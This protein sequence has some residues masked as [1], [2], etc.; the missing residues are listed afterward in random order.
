MTAGQRYEF[1][2]KGWLHL[3]GA[4]T[5]AEL[6]D[7]RAA[8]YAA[9]SGEPRPRAGPGSEGPRFDPRL[10]QLAFNQVAWPV[11]M[12][13]TRGQPMVRLGF[14]SVIHNAP[15]SGGGGML[16]SN[17]EGQRS[18]T[19]GSPS[20]ARYEV[21]RDGTIFCQDFVVFCYLEDVNAGDGGVCLISASHKARFERPPTLFGTF[22][23]GNHANDPPG[24]GVLPLDFKS[25]PIGSGDDEARNRGPPYTENPTP[26]AGDIII[27]SECT[28]HGVIPWRGAGHRYVVKMNFKPQHTAHPE[29]ALKPEEIIRLPPELRELRSYAPPGHVKAIAAAAGLA[30]GETVILLHPP[31]PLLGVSIG[32]ERKRQQND[33]LANG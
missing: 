30:V 26:R 13:L 6:E 15:S 3:P 2:L 28:T 11:V 29:D 24:S 32:T 10:G 27:M 8:A 22:G 17:R 14:G 9:T 16:H 31:L 7:G 4:L 5:P 12:E 33:S 23:T 18:S 25:A 21:G 19:V 1:D 20:M